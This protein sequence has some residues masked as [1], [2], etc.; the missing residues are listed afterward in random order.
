MPQATQASEP[1]A[2]AAA[3]HALMLLKSVVRSDLR[4]KDA[5]VV[6]MTSPIA[7]CVALELNTLAPL[8]VA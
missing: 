8:T 3:A 2:S 6:E 1:K 7:I 4:I 5:A